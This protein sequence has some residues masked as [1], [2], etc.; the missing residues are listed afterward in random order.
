MKKYWLAF[1]GV[2]VGNAFA[3]APNT[4]QGVV[5]ENGCIKAAPLDQILLQDN[6]NL[7]G[8][9]WEKPKNF[10]DFTTIERKVLK[11]EDSLHFSNQSND[12]RSDT[13]FEIFTK[14]FKLIKPETYR[15]SFDAY[16]NM[17]TS[18][19]KGFR[20]DFQNRICFYDKDGKVIGQRLFSFIAGRDNFQETVIS[21]TFP[22][23][24][25]SFTFHLGCDSPNLRRKP[26]QFFALRNL[27]IKVFDSGTTWAEV[28]EFTSPVFAIGS[29]KSL[30]W[31]VQGK[32]QFQIAT[33]P[34]INGF[35]GKFTAFSGPDGS[36]DSWFEKNGSVLS[37]LPENAKYIRY[38][39]K[40]I[41]TTSAPTILQEV[42]I[43]GNKD[44][45]WNASF[46]STGPLVERISESP[47]DD[48]GKPLIVKITDDSGVDWSSL[49][50]SLDNKKKAPLAKLTE[51]GIVISPDKQFKRGLHTLNVSI[52]DFNGNKT[53]KLVFFFIGKKA[54]KG[55]VTLR[56]DAVMLID[57]KPFFPIGLYNFSKQKFNNNDLDKG[58]EVLKEAGFNYVCHWPT[59]RNTTFAEYLAAV[60]KHGFKICLSSGEGG[61]NDA[62]LER[63]AWHLAN[64]RLN[65]NLIMWYIGDD[66]A[67]YATPA[68]LQE[69]TAMVKSIAPH[70]VTG[71]ADAPY[72]NDASR[73]RNYT[74]ATKV[75]MPELYPVRADT[76]QNRESSV[77]LII[78]DMREINKDIAVT[79]A[80]PVAVWPIIQYFSGYRTWKRFP[81]RDELWA[82]SYASIINGAN[83]ITWYTYRTTESEGNYGVTSTPERWNNMRSLALEIKSLTPVLVSRD[84]KEKVVP[85][86]IDGPEFDACKG[87]SI[88][89]RVKDVKGGKYV[90][91]V[92]STLKDVTAEFFV[93]N[94]K[95]GRHLKSG[96]PLKISDGKF[97]EKF[98]P[99]EVKVMIIEGNSKIK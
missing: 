6:F 70:L 15:I 57:G 62:D 1:I 61:G 10:K 48:A 45:N 35:P 94:A 79:G 39:A 12:P 5:A 75:F 72:W 64:D 68:Q 49:R 89:V 41:S 88:T 25:Q 23:G 46:D 67:N 66:T 13:A 8:Q 76:Q 40:M 42:S 63:V 32:V 3:Y 26:Q 78:R 52:A 7:D 80:A 73:Y 36:A 98:T 71:Q 11:N 50:L 31:K 91:A 4:P 99:Y 53:E 85:R 74:T 65:P 9:A 22:T 18:G 30:S 55:I 38:R 69:R 83:G 33:A 16:A 54:K 56:D 21:G 90:F 37:A 86:I 82:M 34:E 43:A 47:V 44:G 97:I 24:T 58:L 2:L 92:N 87:A 60:K 29:D 20:G 93:R 59:Y 17:H 95:K 19:F 77:A 14:P 51:K 96:E 28:S 84:S 81:T 27:V